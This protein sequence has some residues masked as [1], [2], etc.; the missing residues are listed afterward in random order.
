L[1]ENYLSVAQAAEYLT[2]AKSTMYQYVHYRTIPHLKIGG[3]IVFSKN[4]LDNW[5][6]KHEKKEVI[7]K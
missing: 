7:R 3:R 6:M 2:L 4:E 5:I 1:K